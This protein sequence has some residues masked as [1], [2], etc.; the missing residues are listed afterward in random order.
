MKFCKLIIIILIV[1]LKTGNV[2]SN[3]NIFNV[4]N[5][6][7]VKNS[8]SSNDELA[9]L[10]IK[11]GFEKLIKK[12]LLEEDI[13]K[14]SEFKFSQMKE[15][16]MYYQVLNKVTENNGVEKINFNI[17]FDKNKIHN[18][19]YKKNISY[20]EIINKE[21]YLL[22][23]LKK[24]GQIYIFN[25]NFF[26]DNWNKIYSSEL[27]EFILPLE[28]IE[29]IQNV[30]QNKDNLLNLELNN[31]FE[32]YSNKN[33]ALIIIEDKNST[34][35]KIYFK[36]K[37]LGKNIVKNINIKK[38]D[39]S[40][41]KFY[42]KI[43]IEIKKEII[44]LTKSENLI[45]I[46]TPSFLNAQLD[47]TNYSNLVELNLRLKKIDLIENIYVQKFNNNTVYLKLK[48]L[49]KLDKITKLLEDEKIFL[50]LAGDQWRIKIIK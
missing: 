39:L 35:Q 23:I 7:L 45:D 21:L 40:E 15:L 14:L 47:V 26:Y 42:E 8:K 22:P 36:V 16:V 38:I 12:V 25:N 34:E 49:G 50:K 24:N 2:F 3:N 27:I 4:N 44:N 29:I 19:F 18:L 1:F 28:N 20:S 9:N 5:I 11:K 32:E 46:R 37:I 33:S 41:E 48:Y 30:N 13:K 6:E 10:A 43:I 31:L 17:F